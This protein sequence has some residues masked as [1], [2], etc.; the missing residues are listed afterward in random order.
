MQ[1][2][3]SP[4]V[5]YLA[6]L[7]CS[8]ATTVAL[9]QGPTPKFIDASGADNFKVHFITQAKAP[10]AL[11]GRLD[12]ACWKQA[13]P[14]TDFGHCEYGARR[15]PFP[16]TE[17]R[18]LW[19]DTYLYIGITCY[20]D[21]PA[22]L[23]RHNRDTNDKSKWIFERD[24]ME[25]HINGNNDNATRFQTWFIDTGEKQIYWHYD[26]G[27][28]ILVN[29]SYGLA[30]DWD[31][32]ST[33]GP[34]YWQIEA[35]MALAH[36]QVE[37]RI[38]YIFG[39]NPCRFRF[40]KSGV[41]DDGQPYDHV[42][43]FLTWSTQGGDHHDVRLY[44]KCIL[45][46]EPPASVAA[47]LQLAF[48]DLDK[49]TVMVQTG[50]GFDVLDHGKAY[51]QS[52]LERARTELAAAQA[53]AARFRETLAIQAPPTVGQ[54]HYETYAKPHMEKLAA[55]ATGLAGKQQLTVAE[56]NTT[57]KELDEISAAIDGFNWDAQ[58]ALLL[59]EGTPRVTV[60]LKPPANAPVGRDEPDNTPDPKTRNAPCVPWARN[61][62]GGRTSA[63]IVVK[64]AASWDAYALQQRLDLDAEV[65]ACTGGFSGPGI[66]PETDYYKESIL[67]YPQKKAQL[68][69]LLQKKYDAYIFMSCGPAVLPRDSQY[70]IT[71]R[72]LEGAAVVLFAGSEWGFPGLPNAKREQ[73][74]SLRES[75]P[76]K[77]MTR[78]LPVATDW[79][80]D[81]RGMVLGSLARDTVPLDVAPVSKLKVGKGQYATFSGG[82]AGYWY[83]TPLSPHVEQSPDELFQAEYFCGLAAKIVLD[84]VAKLPARR[85]LSV[86]C[87]DAP[88]PPNVAGQ[89][90]LATS[91]PA[92]QG[93]LRTV[94]RDQWG[95]IVQEKQEEAVLPAG[96]GA[97]DVKL[98]ALPA[99]NYYVDVILEQGGKTVDWASQRFKVQG[100]ATIQAVRLEKAT[101]KPGERVVAE[102]TV[103]GASPETQ[104]RAELRDVKGRVLE[105]VARI[106]LKDGRCRVEMPLARA[107]YTYQR[108]DVFVESAGTV[109]DRATTAFYFRH[110]EREDFTV[111]T[112]AADNNRVGALRQSILRDFGI[113]LFETNGTTDE[114]LG[115][116][117]DMAM[118]YW[119][120]GSHN[121]TGGSLASETYHTN[122]AE[123]FRKL[124]TDATTRNVRFISTGD[125]SG[126][127]A[128]F[129]ENYPNWVMP[130]VKRFAE[131]YPSVPR[132][133]D[134]Y[135]MAPA[136]FFKARGLAN[137]GEYWRWMWNMDVKALLAM[138][139]QPGDFELFV[140]AFKE[141]YPDIAA[142]NRAHGTAFASFAAITPADLPTLKQAM[143]PDALG[144]QDW[145]SR[146]Y[147]NI[148]ALNAAWG[149]EEK[150]FETIRP[151]LLL[152]QL[153]AQGRYAA[154]LDKQAYLEDLFI[155]NMQSAATAV[156]AVDPSIG[157]GQG[158]ASFNNVIPEVLQ[159]TDT[160][161]PYLADVNV[162]IGRSLPHKWLGQTLGVYG[163][164]AVN[165]AARRQQTWHVLFTG[166]N[167]I[168]FWSACTGGLMGD[169][170]TN[171]NRSGAMLESIR[172]IQQGIGACLLRGQRQHDGMAILHSR[173]SG[174]MSGVVKEMSTQADS[175]AAFQKLVEDLGMQYRYVSTKEVEGGGLRG[176]EF[177]VLMLPYTQILTPK[178]VAEI[179]AFTK[180]GGTVV[181]DLRAGTFS[182]AGVALN[183]GALDGLFGITRADERAKPVRGTLAVEGLT[184]APCALAGF[185]ADG[186]VIAKSAKAYG[187]V[188]AAPVLLV[189]EVGKGKGI[190]LNVGLGSYDFLLSRNGLGAGR[191]AFLKLFAL[192]GVQPRFGVTAGGN[193]VPGVELAVFKR[194]AAEY[195]TV[196]KRSFAFEKYPLPAEI[197]LGG[198]YYV[199]DL[200]TGKALG[201]LER[202]PLQLEGLGCSVFS[203]LP[204]KVESVNV[205]A[206]RSVKAGADLKL[207]IVLKTT[208][209]PAPH[210][211]RVEVVAA[212]GTHPV[213]TQK[214]DATAG[215]LTCV[216]PVAFNEPAGTWTITVTD[217]STGLTRKVTTRV[218]SL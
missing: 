30:A 5:K 115:N 139:L 58:R 48:P 70:L 156:H 149:A 174:H 173:A 215:T 42:T 191:Q 182:A 125:D 111:F 185:Q 162:E 208:A 98:P 100:A 119:L 1:L 168:W 206:P 41:R 16:K 89:A 216:L 51:Q 75:M 131:K 62:V 187:K 65:F 153:L 104:L 193:E 183:P 20:E 137:G 172:E 101:L 78:L 50:T 188:G 207:D 11:D 218:D 35:R 126:V 177:K 148:A 80:V 135:P 22:N 197:V 32:T 99:G 128:D 164:K 106:A 81:H 13:E 130:L 105:R 76:W 3:T 110:P 192:A 143:F 93:R 113:G 212:D 150:G 18:Y 17:I 84:A 124:A 204:Y 132:P 44:G 160:F 6:L 114:M 56:L 85:A 203:L 127:Q 8:L 45:V 72:L 117:G 123:T 169:L 157:I 195:L 154:A 209:A 19:D 214:L 109:Q 141:A 189:N 166:G 136:E 69:R 64:D 138:K 144:F 122:L 23:D 52:Y 87:G 38:G 201:Q 180:A 2:R 179:E 202:L 34:D 4:R 57:R 184:A 53:V 102:V 167:F 60:T 176:G 26:F 74:T 61:H 175:E 190:L 133:G 36:I 33:R 196:E 178:E 94:V 49:R 90:S 129:A 171:P 15:F 83:T 165:V 40:D 152:P 142:F 186:S 31:Y 59:A 121:M 147:G 77:T 88:L 39:M 95:G 92:W 155:R 67:L 73:D 198:M 163:G 43:Q 96:D 205:A 12:D 145:L 14:I 146:K 213:E 112:D 211:L 194:D 108:L 25:L 161:A 21:T 46:A 9:A 27:W 54:K 79:Q 47:G 151:G 140:A 181:A 120:T 37:P 158:A 29:E 97:V 82:G 103:A 86:K 217:V 91:G 55:M 199:T 24:C 116:G 10:P 107:W 63:L 68:D 210:V 28:G 66:G 134:R 71:Q 200:R 7:V 170:T 118:R 159:Y